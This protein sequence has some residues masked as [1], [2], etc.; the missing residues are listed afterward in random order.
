MKT[1][2]R[3]LILTLV[4]LLLTS[5][6]AS[7]GGSYDSADIGYSK[8][9]GWYDEDDWSYGNSG[10]ADGYYESSGTVGGSAPIVNSASADSTGSGAPAGENPEK[11]VY[12]A[13][14][15]MEVMEFDRAIETLRTQ[16]SAVGG[17]VQNE[18]FSD[19]MP[20]THYYHTDSYGYYSTKVS[21][22]K[23]YY[24]EI[25]IPTEQFRNFVDTAATIGHLRSSSSQVTN[26]SQNYYSNKAYLDSCYKQMEI[27][28][29]MYDEAQTI[30][31]MITIESRIAEVQ[32]QINKLTTVISSMDRDVAYSTVVLRID[33]VEVYSDT[34]REVEEKSFL[35]NVKTHFVASWIGFVDFLQELVYWIIDSMWGLLFLIVVLALLF[36]I[37]RALLTHRRKR[38]EKPIAPHPGYQKTVNPVN[39]PYQTVYVK[40]E[41]AD[42]EK[43]AE[44]QGEEQK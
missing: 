14:I 42:T 18:N 4:C 10:Y 8:N 1:K 38:T 3:F 6:L 25:R 22:Y 32:S 15:T 13:D 11:L 5:M 20:S 37:I 30:S 31:D 17:I 43:P 28:Q 2:H 36:L 44:N 27:L 21:G 35:D 41:D 39:N 33:E 23:S 12:R 29:S 7:C 16:I 34:P 26:I 19:D 40:P 9:E 24:A